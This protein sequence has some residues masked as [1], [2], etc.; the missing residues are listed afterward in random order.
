MTF[1]ELGLVEND[2]DG[3][4][5]YGDTVGTIDMNDEGVAMLED[6]I[7]CTKDFAQKK[8][9]YSKSIH[10]C[11]HKKDGSMH[12]S[13]RMK[14]QRSYTNMALLY[15]QIIRNIWQNRWQNWLLLSI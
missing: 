8:S 13:I 1:N 9:E 2:Y 15:L 11:I 14:Q 3:G 6:N 4:Y 10:L 7:F 12:A 5:G